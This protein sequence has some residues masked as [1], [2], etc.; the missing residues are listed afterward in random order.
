MHAPSH[1]PE[2]KTEERRLIK[3]SPH[4]VTLQI[5]LSHWVPAGLRLKT[6]YLENCTNTTTLTF[7]LYQQTITKFHISATFSTLFINH[8]QLH[9]TV[10]HFTHPDICFCGNNLIVVEVHHLRGTI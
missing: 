9:Q 3:N 1:Q 2:T 10:G 5:S 6:M 8:E 7:L 4:Q